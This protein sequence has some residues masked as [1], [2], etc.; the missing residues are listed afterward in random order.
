VSSGIVR[1]GALL[2]GALLRRM[3]RE[4]LVL[5][6]LVFPIALTSTMLVGTPGVVAV[7]KGPA[8][9]GIGADVDASLLR[10]A[11][12][13]QGLRVDVVSD[14]ERST[15]DGSVRVGTDG[16]TIWAASANTDGLVVEAALREGLGTRWRLDPITLLPG[17]RDGGPFGLMIGRLLGA[18]FALYGVVIGAGMVARDR[19]EGTLEAE[20]ALPLPRWIHGASRWVSGTLVLTAFIVPG[21]LLFDALIGVSAIGSLAR[22]IVAACATTTALGLFAVGRSGARGGLA[23]PLAGG[24]SAATGVFALGLAVPEVARLLPLASLTC[25]GRGYVPLLVSGLVGAGAIAHFARVN[26]G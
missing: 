24:L 20:L 8:V 19:D 9:V 11:A 22:N 16:R 10:D 3:L 25:D 5:R 7:L 18:V 4:S 21:L 1:A 13:A 2:T 26:R 23:G 14:P 6:S 15:R 12:S 17:V